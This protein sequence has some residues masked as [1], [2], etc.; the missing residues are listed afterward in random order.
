MVIIS[1]FSLQPIPH[2]LDRTPQRSSGRPAA[3]RG[4]L[5][6]LL[7]QLHCVFSSSFML[8]TNIG[9][10][11]KV[12][13]TWT[14]VATTSATQHNL[15]AQLSKKN[16]STQQRPQARTRRTRTRST[17]C[18]CLELWSLPDQTKHQTKRQ[19]AKLSS[20]QYKNKDEHYL[21]IF[22]TRQCSTK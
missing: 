15:T 19:I 12:L 16:Q 1:L 21:V 6:A 20:V 9:T 5:S 7:Q 17:T 18:D 14:K 11:T 2:L 13:T 4:W 8:C 10:E 3:P 22:P